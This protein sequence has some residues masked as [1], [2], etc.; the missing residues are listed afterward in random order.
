MVQWQREIFAFKARIYINTVELYL[1]GMHAYIEIRVHVSGMLDVNMWYVI[2][3]KNLSWDYITHKYM[4][5]FEYHTLMSKY[6][7]AL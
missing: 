6:F 3:N 7:I 1:F 5:R 2:C 4:F